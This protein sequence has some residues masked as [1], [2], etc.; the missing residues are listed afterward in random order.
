MRILPFIIEWKFPE[1]CSKFSIAFFYKTQGKIFFFLLFCGCVSISLP[2][3]NAYSD[4]ELIKMIKWE[5]EKN[6]MTFIIQIYLYLNI[7]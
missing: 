7:A 4:F 1:K 3:A 2:C 6:Q 5:T